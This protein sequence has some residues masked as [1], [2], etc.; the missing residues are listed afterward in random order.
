[1]VSR[2]SLVVVRSSIGV[3]G[4]TGWV[5]PMSRD[6]RAP[7]LGDGQWWFGSSSP[8]VGVKGLA[9]VVTSSPLAVVDWSGDG[10][11]RGWSRD[12]SLAS[13]CDGEQVVAVVVRSSIGVFGET[14]RVN[15]MSLRRACS[16]SLRCGVVVRLFLA[17][18]RCKRLGGGRDFL[19]SR[20]WSTGAAMVWQGG[21][22]R[23]GRG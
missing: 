14:G 11:G 18:C 15:P 17:G 1:M 10:A 13:G 7:L 19:S 9:A 23:G 5:N 20:R 2:W 16:S 6:G 8:V 4:E 3:F 22:R 21:G 12:G